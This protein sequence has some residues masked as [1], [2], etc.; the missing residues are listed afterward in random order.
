[1]DL[2]NQDPSPIG[3]RIFSRPCKIL[4]YLSSDTSMKHPKLPIRLVEFNARCNWS[5]HALLRMQKLS[6]SSECSNIPVFMRLE[7]PL[8]VDGNFIISGD[9]AILGH[10]YHL[11]DDRKT[12]LLL[13]SL[14]SDKLSS[15]ISY[16]SRH[17]FALNTYRS[18][19]SVLSLF[20]Y[21]YFYLENYFSV[22]R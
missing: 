2:E 10:L 1:M 11:L 7:L 14:I 20:Y 15:G 21:Y 9:K 13:E 6:Y 5:I 8:L 3:P 18:T 4:P 12:P 19:A 22:K 17:Q 16:L